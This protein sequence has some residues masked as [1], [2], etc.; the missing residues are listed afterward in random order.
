MQEQFGYAYDKAWNLSGRTNN[1]LVQSFAVNDL[2]QLSSAT[3]SGTLTVAG[4][5][6]EPSG[7][8]PYNNYPGVTTVAVNG[9]SASVY[10]DGTFA[11]AGFT[12]GT[13]NN[14]YTAI[15]HDNIG[16][17]STN[18]VTVNVLSGGSDY[19]YDSNGNLTSDDA[20]AS[21]DVELMLGKYPML[22]GNSIK[23]KSIP[24]KDVLKNKMA[25]NGKINLEGCNA[26]GKNPDSP[27]NLPQAIS[28]VVPNV[29]VSGSTLSTFG[30]RLVEILTAILIFQAP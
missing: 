25:P 1:A 14:T 21:E 12:P 17:L 8:S 4:T 30:P 28:S 11:A 2:N 16:R 13:G 3:Q 9:N 26:A 15:A 29:P 6:T 22:T 27:M 23:G 19:T 18:S 10:G 20:Q 24:L 5:A 7:N